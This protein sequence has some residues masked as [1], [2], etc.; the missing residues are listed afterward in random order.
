MFG[1]RGNGMGLKLIMGMGK[2]KAIPAHL[3]Y[4]GCSQFGW[5]VVTCHT[6]AQL[7]ELNTTWFYG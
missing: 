3:Y 6:V 2:L 5:L 1:W 7:D 4:R